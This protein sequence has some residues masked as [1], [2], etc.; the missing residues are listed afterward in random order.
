MKDRLASI[1]LANGDADT[2]DDAPV[3]SQAVPLIFAGGRST[4]RARVPCR[5]EHP[6]TGAAFGIGLRGEVRREADR[7]DPS[8]IPSI[9]LQER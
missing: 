5:D 9:S 3:V 8:C 4:I 2:G 1:V 7:I 6:E